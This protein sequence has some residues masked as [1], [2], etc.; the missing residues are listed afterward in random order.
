MN[1]PIH[2]IRPI[3][4]YDT[5]GLEGEVLE[6]ISFAEYTVYLQFGATGVQVDNCLRY[7]LSEGAAFVVEE[8]PITS[9]WSIRLVGKTVESAK[10]SQT[11]SDIFVRFSDG[12]IIEF[13]DDGSP[14]DLFGITAPDGDYR[15][16][17]GWSQ[18]GSGP[19]NQ[20]TLA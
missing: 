3:S 7:R 11:G 10:K 16:T 20:K 8:I 19:L 13:V 12:A 14:G 2:I 18:I 15:G 17:G 6:S 1:N 5:K 9:T 4:A